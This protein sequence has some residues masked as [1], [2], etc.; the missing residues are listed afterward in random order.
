MYLRLSWLKIQLLVPE[1]HPLVLD[2]ILSILRKGCSPLSE[3]SFTQC[4]GTKMWHAAWW[5]MYIHANSGF[6]IY[7]I[8]NN[9]TDNYMY[10]RSWQS[11]KM[12][13]S[14]PVLLIKNHHDFQNTHIHVCMLNLFT[15]DPSAPSGNE[16]ANMETGSGSGGCFHWVSKRFDGNGQTGI[17]GAH[18]I[19]CCSQWSVLRASCSLHEIAWVWRSA[20]IS[21]WGRELEVE[22]EEPNE[23]AGVNMNTEAPSGLVWAVGE[24]MEAG[25]GVHGTSPGCYCTCVHTAMC[26]GQWKCWQTFVVVSILATALV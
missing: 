21:N 11:F 23:E 17:R 10:T 22:E 2:R 4:S 15:S 19:A 3:A 13:V 12:K 9:Y 5:C 6:F 8:H 16:E 24:R 7:C 18:S 20:A 14:T 1:S 25:P 26:F